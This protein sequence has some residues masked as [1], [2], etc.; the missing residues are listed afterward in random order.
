[1]GGLA[2]V[3]GQFAFLMSPVALLYPIIC[4]FAMPGTTFRK[5]AFVSANVLGNH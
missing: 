3:S 1:M 4:T 2:I 5:A